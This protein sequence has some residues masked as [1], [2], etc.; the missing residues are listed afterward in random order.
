MTSPPTLYHV[1]K[2]ISSPIYQALIELN[3]V[4]NPVH[5][6]TLSFSDLKTPE[7]LARNPM[8]TSP[9]FVDVA[10]GI[11]IWESGAVLTYLLQAYDTQ[12]VLHP[13][14][15]KVTPKD[16]ATF[17]HLQ[18]YILATVYPFVASL[19]LHTLKPQQDQDQSYVVKGKE[20]WNTKLAPTLA[21]F[22]GDQ[23]YFMGKTMTVIDLLAA[24]PLNNAHAMGLVEEFPTL[25]NLLAKIKARP[26]FVTAYNETPHPL[27]CPECPRSMVLVPGADS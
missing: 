15:G 10:T 8:G 9:T 3:I 12:H 4:D 6:A 16:N 18:Q 19:Y 23:D 2:T 21:G 5:V 13:D 26:S 1:P 17:L 25:H 11:D 20:T 22:L 27:N 14:I 7:H 24:K